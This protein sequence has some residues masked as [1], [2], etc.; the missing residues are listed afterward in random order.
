MGKYLNTHLIFRGG[1]LE[2]DKSSLYV[3]LY[4][5]KYYIYTLVLFLEFFHLSQYQ[6]RTTRYGLNSFRYLASKT[7]NERP[8]HLW[9]ENI[10]QL[11]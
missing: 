5:F 7:W 1:I 2:L 11:I 8:D 4:L 6:V 9:K 10:F 3:E